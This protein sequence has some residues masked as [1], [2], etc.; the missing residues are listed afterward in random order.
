M[1][2]T[3]EQIVKNYNTFEAIVDNYIT[4]ERKEKV[5]AMLEKIGDEMAIAPAAGKSW[6]HGAYPG[7]YLVHVIGVVKSAIKLTKFYEDMGGK[8]DY[9]MEEIVF[10]ALFHDLGK[11]GNGE[12]PNY[13]PQDNEWRRNNLQEIYVNNPELDFML[14]PD[15]SLFVLQKFGIQVD[16]KEWLGIKLHDG[17]FD[18]SNKAYFSANKPDSRLKTNLVY[19]LHVADYLA[20]KFETDIEESQK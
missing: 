10:A 19:V 18:E 4:G 7:G 12:L 6:F 13:I 11:L 20:S 14:V 2:L 8:V 15:R 1:K 9:T 16:Q 17:V 5:K 3:E